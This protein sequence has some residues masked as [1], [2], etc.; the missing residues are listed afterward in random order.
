M[1]PDFLIEHFERVAEAPGAPDKL[2]DIIL[3]LA[4]RG[5]LVDQNHE[6]PNADSVITS[7]L[8][9]RRKLE[10]SGEI[11]K[12]KGLPTL[13][14]HEIPHSVPCSWTW[15]RLGNICAYNARQKVSPDQI[16]DNSWVLDLEDIEKETSR[17]LARK[18]FSEVRSKSTKSRFLEG[19]VL[20][21][22]LRPYLNKVVVADD[23]G[24]CTTEIAPLIPFSG[25]EAR[26]LALMLRRRSFVDYANQ[27][28][29][30]I[31]LP[32]LNAK[33]AKLAPIPVPPSEEQ[34]R[35]VAKV[36]ELMAKCDELERRQE[37]TQETRI[38]VHKA[39]LSEFIEA[40]TAEKLSSAWQRL[41]DNFDTLHGTQDSVEELKRAIGQ[42]AVHGRLV[43]PHGDSVQSDAIVRKAQSYLELATADFRR[44]SQK[45]STGIAKPLPYPEHWTKVAVSDVV[46]LI[47]GRAFKPSEWSEEGLPIVRI[48][49]LNDPN[50]KYNFCDFDVEEKFLIENGDLLVSWSG[51]PGTSFGAF[52][53]TGNKAVLNQHIFKAIFDR[54]NLLDRYV[55]LAIDDLMYR[56]IGDSVGGV[57][58]KHVRRGQIEGSLIGIP[59][60]AEQARI[61]A[62]VDNLMEKCDELSSL[63]LANDQIKTSLL[64]A[65]VHALAAA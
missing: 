63:T 10:D 21:G 37:A 8:K 38:R 31:N 46:F 29:Y 4:A 59:P 41:S 24:Y 20:Y 1:T 9:S 54:S 12:E 58:L 23:D 44:G 33:D 19:D 3:E 16:L 13:S 50:A 15:A 49:N 62:T 28:T 26:F 64:D 42:V 6:G 32:R 47:N 36:D 35:I 5:A 45:S 61:V 51:T 40:D 7:V 34:A 53:W 57:G 43:A 60:L 18:T 27:K 39:S 22:K 11:K 48:Q 30:G 52:I 55:L 2:R 56:L 65:T 17:I 25:I 14:G